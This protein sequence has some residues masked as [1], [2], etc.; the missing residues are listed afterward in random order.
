[1][2]TRQMPPFGFSIVLIKLKGYEETGAQGARVPDGSGEMSFTKPRG[3]GY[4]D[5][6]Q[7]EGSVGLRVGCALRPPAR[8]CRNTVLCMI[9]CFS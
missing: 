1:M 7:R 3:S 8:A 9:R 4:P 6:P 2:A 5:P